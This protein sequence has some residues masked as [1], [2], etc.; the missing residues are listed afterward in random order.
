MHR[1][2][3]YIHYILDADNSRVDDYV[4][5]AEYFITFYTN[6][7]TSVRPVFLLNFQELII[8]TIPRVAN[9]SLNV[10][11]SITEVH[12]AVFSM[13]NRKSLGLDGMSPIFFKQF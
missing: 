12:K 8:L 4:N 13:E 3:N 2:H 11:P 9:L 10:V 1:K 6:L 5:I 7:F